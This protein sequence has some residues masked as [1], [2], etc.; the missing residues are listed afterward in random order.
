M[1]WIDLC[2]SLEMPTPT[3]SDPTPAS[4][5]YLTLMDHSDPSRTDSGH[6]TL[7]DIM[8]LVERLENLRDEQVSIVYF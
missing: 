3:P 7:P 8:N 5:P 6:G 4:I 1:F 2:V